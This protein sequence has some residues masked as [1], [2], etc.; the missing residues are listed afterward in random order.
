M[1]EHALH[2]KWTP[3][4]RKYNFLHI[5]RFFFAKG[6][7]ASPAAEDGNNVHGLDTT[8]SNH[9]QFQLDRFRS[10]TF[11]VRGA[12]RSGRINVKNINKIMNIA[13]FDRHVSTVPIGQNIQQPKHSTTKLL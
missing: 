6:E 12:P 4:M 11:D 3:A 10:G 7:N 1:V 2:H 13:K 8:T 9:A 5:L